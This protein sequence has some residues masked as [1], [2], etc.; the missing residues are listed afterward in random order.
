MESE[1]KITRE[2]KPASRANLSVLAL[3]SFLASFIIARAFTTINPDVF[4]G[5][6]GFHIHHFWYGII[7]L[8]I[9]GWL[10]ISYNEERITRIAAVIYGAGGGLIG[11][12]A[13]L[14]VGASYWTGITYTIVVVFLVF[15]STF[16]LFRRYS[17]A[18]LMEFQGLTRSRVGFY[19]GIILAAVSIAFIRTRN[20]FIASLSTAT[21]IVACII[22][23][24]YIAHQIS[25]RH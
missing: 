14:L 1:L 24:A 21:T 10:G 25:A 7:M 22:I 15:F 20:F 16:I 19:F 4:L 11:D 6:G 13:G 2:E 3:I 17:R 12:E 23:I 5:A 9:G 8:A 18:I